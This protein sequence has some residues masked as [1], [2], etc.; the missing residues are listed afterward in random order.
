MTT[1]GR[2][3]QRV[4]GIAHFPFRDRNSVYSDY[5]VSQNEYRLV[6]NWRLR[7]ARALNRLN[8]PLLYKSQYLALLIELTEY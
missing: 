8:E 6:A 1:F 3:M 5:W 2:I 7:Y 4:G